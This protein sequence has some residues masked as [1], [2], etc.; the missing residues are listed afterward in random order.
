M[1]PL[2]RDSL[3]H[4][5]L[6][7]WDGGRGARGRYCVYEHIFNEIFQTVVDFYRHVNIMAVPVFARYRA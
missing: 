4:V 2:L 5:L 6:S 3:Q 7:G 1:N